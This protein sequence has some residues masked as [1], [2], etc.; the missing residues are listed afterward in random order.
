MRS[1]LEQRHVGA[2][3]AQPITNSTAKMVCLTAAIIAA[4]FLIVDRL[5][6]T[7]GSVTEIV[8]VATEACTLTATTAAVLWHKVIRPLRQ[9]ADAER[10][11]SADREHALLIESKRQEFE[12]S[13]HRAMEMT[14]T[15][16]AL[17]RTTAKAIALGAPHVD[18]E[19][20]LADSS[21]A[22][23][24]RAVAVGGDKR[25]ARCGVVAPRDCPA[26]RRAQT[27]TFTSS[28]DLEACPH[29]ENRDTGPCAAVCVPVSVG[30][31]SIG[32]LHA[33]ADPTWRPT[34][35]DASVLEAVATETGSRLGMLRVMEAVHLQAATDPL[36][37]LLNRR[38]FENHAQGMIRR[39]VPFTL[40]MGDLDH[41]KKLN[42]TTDMTP[43]TGHCVRSHRRC[44][45]R[46]VA[47]TWSAATAGRSS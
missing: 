30:G 40:A 37:G 36:T 17:Y 43:A 2:L 1:R 4:E 44:A 47:R 3:P 15:E 11:I 27:L 32:V 16:E 22:H 23:L 26:I 31:R 41:F 39:N 14:G 38:S 7:I 18:A 19:I 33:A 46:S 42:D 29:L 21:D 9:E 25:H 24:K 34:A 10:E 5:L 28:E 8:D 35:A 12:A 6:A 45:P 20:L 13:L